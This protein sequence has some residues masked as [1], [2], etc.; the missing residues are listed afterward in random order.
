MQMTGKTGRNGPTSLA[1]KQLAVCRGRSGSC[2]ARKSL[3]VLPVLVVV[4][5]VPRRYRSHLADCV[6]LIKAPNLSRSMLK[7][8]STKLRLLAWIAGG[9]VSLFAAGNAS[10]AD[11]GCE[12]PCD[13]LSAELTG[14]DCGCTDS[15]RGHGLSLGFQKF[16]ARLK[17]LCDLK[18]CSWKPCGHGE[19]LCDDSCDAALMDDLMYPVP[20]EMH[21]QHVHP[22]TELVPHPALL[23][24]VHH[25]SA[26]SKEISPPVHVR[27]SALDS[28]LFDSLPDPFKDDDAQVQTPRNIRPSS[29][30]EVVLKPVPRRPLSQLQETSSRRDKSVR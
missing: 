9:A 30:D 13:A 29:H 7:R 24:E 15:H 11:C 6:F 12:I 3:T 16:Q 8:P 22:H 18:W 23:P 20:M 25:P 10:A 4:P 1:I 19:N 28:E 26:G 17:R 2:Q 21:H 14:C 5:I 27:E